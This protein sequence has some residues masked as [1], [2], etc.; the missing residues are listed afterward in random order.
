[1]YLP[2]E[3]CDLIKA[4]VGST[5]KIHINGNIWLHHYT[6]HTINSVIKNNDLMRR[7]LFEASYT[8]PKYDIGSLVRH[9]NRET[10]IQHFGH[11]AD[12]QIP[13]VHGKRL[14][15]NN[16]PVDINSIVFYRIHDV[17]DFFIMDVGCN[18]RQLRHIG[19]LVDCFFQCSPHSR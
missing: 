5:F 11:D 14:S 10:L 1:M 2:S 3:L 8:P 9:V 18:P 6:L 12:H 4:Y 15:F 17:T 19:H 13:M 16:T 7:L